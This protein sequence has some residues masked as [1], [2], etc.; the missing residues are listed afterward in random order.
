[1]TDTSTPTR[2]PRPRHA[3]EFDD[4]HYHDDDEEVQ[5]EEER[6]RRANADARR[7]ALRRLAARERPAE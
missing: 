1:M 5:T 6:R 7:Q 3:E 2:D 4:P